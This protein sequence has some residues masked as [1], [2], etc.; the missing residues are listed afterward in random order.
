MKHRTLY[1]TIV[2]ASC[3]CMTMNAAGQTTPAEKKKSIFTDTKF[4]GYLMSEYQY[5]NPKG[6]ENNSF[7]IRMARMSLEGRILNDFYWKTQIQ[8]NGNT[9][10]LGQS[11]RVVDVLAEWQKYSYFKVRFGQ[12]K[13]AFTFENPIHPITQGFMSFGQNI[14]KLSGFSDRT[15]EH[16]SNGRDIGIQVQGDFLKNAAGRDLLHYQVGVYNGQG[17]NTKDLDQRKDVIGGLWVMPVKGMRIGVFGWTGSYARK[18]SYTL[19]DEQTHQPVLDTNGKAQTV[20][21]LQ[22]VE[23]NRYAVS[24]EYLVNDWTF[25][26]EYIH[27]QGY[28]FKTT[29]NTREDAAKADINYAAGDKADGFYALVIAPV[30]KKKLHVKARYDMYRPQADWNTSKTQ[31]EVGVNYTLS[32]NLIFS[33][34]YAWV[35]DRSL[36]KHNYSLVD[37]QVSVKF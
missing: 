16:S 26:S 3:L 32:G 21:G 29:H 28:G 37:F 13:R 18:G 34:E 8:F 17:I 23:R 6:A 30:V 27:S 1:Q 9:A 11:P 35:N 14:L 15:G 19:V 2:V 20:S 36:E 10:T 31:Y 24:G 33:G 25:R 5:S 12:F 7:N 22:V 4:S